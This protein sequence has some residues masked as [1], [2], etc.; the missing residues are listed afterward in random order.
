MKRTPITS[1]SGQHGSHF[2]ELLLTKG[3]EVHHVVRRD[4]TEDLVP[5]ALANLRDDIRL[6]VGTLDI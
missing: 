2:A 3:Y 5:P 6:Y 1:V 4:A